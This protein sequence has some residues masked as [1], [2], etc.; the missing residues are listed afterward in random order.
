MISL[1]PQPRYPLLR[2]VTLAVAVLALA[3]AV[4]GVLAT[5]TLLAWVVAGIAVVTFAASFYLKAG[6]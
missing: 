4:T 6:L 3:V 2:T 1:N 5:M